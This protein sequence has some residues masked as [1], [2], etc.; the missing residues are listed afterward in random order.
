M[1]AAQVSSRLL[2]VKL[3]DYFREVLRRRA[4]LL[5]LLEKA[6]RRPLVGERIE[7]DC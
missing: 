1:L 2:L 5:Q 6:F 3:G 7:R 4:L